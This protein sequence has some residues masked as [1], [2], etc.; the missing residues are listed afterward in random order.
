VVTTPDVT[1]LRLNR[2]GNH[3]VF[4]LPARDEILA[5]L[6]DNFEELLNER[7]APFLEAGERF[8]VEIN[9]ENQAGVSSR[10]LGSLIALGKVLRP[11]FGEVR[12]TNVNPVVR[13]LFQLTRTDQL[14]VFE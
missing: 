3:L 14:F 6:P 11:H 9:L 10:Q 2:E 13:Q 7:L 12:V 1:P 5:Q 8:T 4:L